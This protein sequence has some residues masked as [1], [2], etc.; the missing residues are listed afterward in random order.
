MPVVIIPAITTR[1]IA[2]MSGA[3]MGKA[4]K[5]EA[6][7]V[8]V[9]PATRGV[10]VY[11]NAKIVQTVLAPYEDEKGRLFGPQVMYEKVSEGRM[12]PEALEHP[13]LAYI[14]PDN[15]I[16]PPGMGNPVSGVAMQRAA[17]EAPR[18]PTDLIDPRDVV[19]TGLL[20][21]EANRGEADRMASAA[22]RRA[23]F[24]PDIGWILVPLSPAK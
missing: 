18:M 7:P 5:G 4:F 17:E 23:V 12:N 9:T 19:V 2:E 22:G 13:E 16:V 8:A 6:A 11:T 21:K 15:L 1:P 14:P 20:S 3:P 24:D 10:P